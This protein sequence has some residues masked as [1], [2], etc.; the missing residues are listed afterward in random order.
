M[1]LH[2]AQ[3]PVISSLRLEGVQLPAWIAISRLQRRELLRTELQHDL[4]CISS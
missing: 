1:A 3:T 4:H 2:A